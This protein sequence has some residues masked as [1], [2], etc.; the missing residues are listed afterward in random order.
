MMSLGGEWLSRKLDTYPRVSDGWVAWREALWIITCSTLCILCQ[1]HC[2]S[3]FRHTVLILLSLH[4]SSPCP[5][6]P[7]PSP[8]SSPPAVHAA[9]FSYCACTCL[10]RNH[11][12]WSLGIPPEDILLTV[13]AVFKVD[14]ESCFPRGLC[15]GPRITFAVLAVLCSFSR[16]L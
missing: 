16:W 11:W 5:P 9:T 13:S 15:G 10:V 6:P 12:D 8:A 1:K 2:F 7:P 4:F 3:Y 14:F